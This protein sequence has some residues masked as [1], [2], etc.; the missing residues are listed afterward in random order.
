[1]C[2]NR[3]MKDKKHTINK[4]GSTIFLRVAVVVIGL[5]ILTICVLPIPLILQ[6]GEAGVYT[7]ILLGLYVPTIPFFFALYQALKLLGYIDKNKAFSELSVTALKH[8]KRCAAII[9]ALF[10]AGMP[11]LFYAAEK[12]DAPGVIVMG[13]VII[14]ASMAI[15]VFAAVL[16]R[17]LRNAIDIK[18]ENDL[19]V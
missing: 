13:L 7:P 6:T 2:L 5:T 3:C 11:Y 1:M 12:D 9:G 4:R 19:T 10:A 15:G 14:F 18:S 16:Q 17:L 8:I